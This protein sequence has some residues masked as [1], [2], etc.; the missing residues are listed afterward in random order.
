MEASST[1]YE[2]LKLV[3]KQ[4][5][6]PIHVIQDSLLYLKQYEKSFKLDHNNI[7]VALSG[8]LLLACKTH[9][10]NIRIRGK[11]Y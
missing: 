3:G 11:G 1:I 7:E 5:E 2:T 4:L 6:L 9:D 8:C 10:Y